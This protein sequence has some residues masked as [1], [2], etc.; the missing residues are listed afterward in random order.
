MTILENKMRR[1]GVFAWSAANAVAANVFDT[2]LSHW[3]FKYCEWCCQWQSSQVMKNSWYRSKQSIVFFQI[4]WQCIPGNTAY[5]EMKLCKK[6]FELTHN[7]KLESKLGKLSV[8]F[9]YINVK[10]I[11][12]SHG[13]VTNREN[14][15]LVAYDCSVPCRL[16]S[17]SNF[18]F[19]NAFMTS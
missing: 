18:S 1:S 8:F 4:T 5:I 13:H 9:A 16:S 15:I 19:L 14:E 10:R 3:L 11:F 12:K 2:T 7:T 6:Y 17:T